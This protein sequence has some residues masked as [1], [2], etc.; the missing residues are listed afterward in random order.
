MVKNYLGPITREIKKKIIKKLIVY[1]VEYFI[2]NNS[3]FNQIK[4]IKN[5][6][7]HNQHANGY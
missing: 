3:G 2:P 4:L 5:E 7:S 6:H 1:T